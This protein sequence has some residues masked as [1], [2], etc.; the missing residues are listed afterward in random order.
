MTLFEFKKFVMRSLDPTHMFCIDPTPGDWAIVTVYSAKLVGCL[1]VR[2]RILG[3]LRRVGLQA[4]DFGRMNGPDAITMV[5]PKV[6]LIARG[7]FDERSRLFYADR[8]NEVCS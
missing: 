4:Y 7:E 1:N 3:M 5:S 2:S 6:V 8:K